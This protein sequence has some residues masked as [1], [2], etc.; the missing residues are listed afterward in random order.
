MVPANNKNQQTKTVAKKSRKAPQ[1]IR[2]DIFEPGVV[3]EGGASFLVPRRSSL[4]RYRRLRNLAVVENKVDRSAA[5][6]ELSEAVAHEGWRFEATLLASLQSA[7][8]QAA[9]I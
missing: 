8:G 2:A 4:G 7:I 9:P 1:Q 3:D 5:V 6:E